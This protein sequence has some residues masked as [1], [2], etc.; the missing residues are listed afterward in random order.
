[1][2]KAAMV[3]AFQDEPLFIEKVNQLKKTNKKSIIKL[4]TEYNEAHTLPAEQVSK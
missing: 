1:M 2:S 4:L 3:D